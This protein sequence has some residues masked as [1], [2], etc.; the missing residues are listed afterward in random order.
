MKLARP[1]INRLKEYVSFLQQKLRNPQDETNT[2][3]EAY[4]REIIRSEKSI[5]DLFAFSSSVKHYN[6]D[7]RTSKC[8]NNKPEKSEMY[9]VDKLLICLNSL[10]YLKGKDYDC[11][12]ID[13][14]ETFLN[15]WFNND[16][17]KNKRECWHIF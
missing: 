4:K 14:I 3:L 2:E 13:E 11:I 1:E 12:V 5:H 15:Q 17:V 8:K 6:R 16:T 10:H 7:F 9:K